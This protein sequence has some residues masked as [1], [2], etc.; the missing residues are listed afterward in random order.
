MSKKEVQFTGDHASYTSLLKR[1]ETLQA[2]VERLK[3]RS[4][5]LR[6][7]EDLT[8][9]LGLMQAGEFRSGNGLEPG[10]GFT[11]GRFGYPGFIYAGLEFFLVGVQNDA[12]QV[13]L[14]LADGTL[15]FGGGAG[16]LDAGGLL[17]KS[18]DSLGD[19]NKIRFLTE[20]GSV[21][22]AE[23][24]TEEVGLDP[25]FHIDTSYRVA[26]PAGLRDLDVLGDLALSGGLVKSGPGFIGLGS[27]AT[28]T[29]AGGVVTATRSCHLID[30]EGGAATDNL[31][32]INT[33]V[34]GD[35]LVLG[36]VASARVPKAKDGTGNLRL[37][38]DFSFT[39]VVDKLTLIKHSSGNWHELG[40]STN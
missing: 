26:I 35:I 15:Y 19:A 12:A 33:G 4:A 9:A 37:A 20:D 36:S 29:I 34:E 32:T 7:L 14:S 22:L 13:G 17:I 11:G 28:L 24:Y 40:R 16:R 38:G 25:S 6:T 3:R 5:P 10:E 39:G 30:T 23:I 8:H 31:D 18:A 27:P 21:V 1:L 2:E